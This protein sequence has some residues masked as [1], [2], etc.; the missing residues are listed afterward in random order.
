M[1]GRTDGRTDKGQA[2]ARQA[3]ADGWAFGRR[4]GLDEY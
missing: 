2:G 3:D 1:D 4:G